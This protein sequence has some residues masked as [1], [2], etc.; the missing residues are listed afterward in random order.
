MSALVKVKGII[1]RETELAL[2]FR[3]DIADGPAS[4]TAWI[5]IG[6]CHHITRHPETGRGRPAVI[7]LPEW[8]ADAKE[9]EVEP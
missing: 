1:L 8:L 2:Q 3:Q 6:S 5:P 9:L 4:H 7:E